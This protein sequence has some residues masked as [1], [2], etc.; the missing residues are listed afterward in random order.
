MTLDGLC[1]Y[2][3]AALFIYLS[4]SDFVHQRI[5][6]SDTLV[7]KMIPVQFF[8]LDYTGHEYSCISVTVTGSVAVAYSYTVRKVRTHPLSA[9]SR[10]ATGYMILSTV[11]LTHYLV[12]SAFVN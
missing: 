10:Y 6:L 9:I 12:G 2:N 3:C 1:L 8:P 11:D 5:E 4:F 7:R